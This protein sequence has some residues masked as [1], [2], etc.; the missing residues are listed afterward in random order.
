MRFDPDMINLESSALLPDTQL[1]ECAECS[2]SIS[3]CEHCTGNSTCTQCETGA[4]TVTVGAEE[5]C[6]YNF[7]GTGGVGVNDGTGA[8]DTCTITGCDECVISGGTETCLRCDTGLYLEQDGL[9]CATPGSGGNLFYYLLPY[10][11]YE[12]TT[13]E[14]T[15]FG[16]TSNTYGM[17]LSNPFFF[18]QQAFTAMASL[19]ADIFGAFSTV[20]LTIYVA[21]GDHY[22]FGCADGLSADVTAFTDVSDFCTNIATLHK[23][24]A[25]FNHVSISIVPLSCDLS[26]SLSTA[27]A[28]VF[29]DNCV[30]TDEKPLMHV[31]DKNFNF[32]ITNEMTI[33]GLEFEAISL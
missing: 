19:H 18:M 16:S 22:L 25:Q 20:D 1:T 8:C 28:L 5:S 14:Q 21:K 24:Y 12:M 6:Y 23:T 3:A 33:S 31:I 10:E 4:F 13:D 2:A 27:D 15:A 30:P 32:N 7:C 11:G 17:T 9:T 29:N 26:L